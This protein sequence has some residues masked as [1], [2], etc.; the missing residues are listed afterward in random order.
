MIN[1]FLNPSRLNRLLS[2]EVQQEI[3]FHAMT[4]ALRTKAS[5]DVP[6]L[7]DL[8]RLEDRV[9]QFGWEVCVAHPADTEAIFED[10]STDLY[11]LVIDLYCDL[12]GRSIPMVHRIIAAMAQRA[13]H[14]VPSYQAMWTVCLY[15]DRIHDQ[16]A[17]IR[18]AM[19]DTVWHICQVPTRVRIA[20]NGEVYSPHFLLLVTN[21]DPPQIVGFQVTR[22]GNL[23][24]DTFAMLYEAIIA[25]RQPMPRET[26]GLV[27]HLPCAIRA[28]RT[29]YSAIYSIC[30]QKGIVVEDKGSYTPE[31]IQAVLRTIMTD[32]CD[33]VSQQSV[34]LSNCSDYFDTYLFRMYGY[35]PM[36][37]AQKRRHD[38]RRLD[39]FNRDPASVFALLRHFLPEHQA[40][41]ENGAVSLHGLHYEHPLLHFWPG[42]QVSV[43][44]SQ[45]AESRC[46]VYLDGE[47]LCEARA[48]EL[49]RLDGTYR[50]NRVR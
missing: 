44:V 48:R 13:G 5:N 43:R 19:T 2:P 27:W 35:S 33:N 17:V 37:E 41:I 26:A 22:P 15:L 36:R 50:D 8:G 49:R 32:W 42:K 28:S 39:G 38:W 31:A 46:W 7:P 16:R 9:H 24:V 21:D 6:G 34:S 14:T 30:S 29:S 11:Q 18:T 40:I 10:V 4:R 47:V 1:P 20:E 45:E 3:H 25:Q 23:R 12:T